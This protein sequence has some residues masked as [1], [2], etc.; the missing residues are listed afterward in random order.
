MEKELINLQIGALLHDI[1]KIVR[2]A[3]KGEKQRH[4]K[5]GSKYL[6]ENKI[7]ETGYEE[8]HE[9]IKY[10][11]SKELKEAKL[12]DNSLAYIVYEAD[13]IASGIDRVKYDETV[14][15]M[16]G[17]EMLPLNSLFNRVKSNIKNNMEEKDK[18]FLW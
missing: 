12:P 13:N 2:R 4:S 6:K 16:Y 18:Y 8:V 15:K 10:H 9:I 14:D 5:A 17:N 7:L 3:G 1:G 11:H